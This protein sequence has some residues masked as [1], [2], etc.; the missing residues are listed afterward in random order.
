MSR[1]FTEAELEELRKAD[2]EIE[3]DFTLTQEDLDFSRNL[4][5]EAK[6]DKLDNRGRK[7]AA[8]QAAYREANREKLR[9]YQRDYQRKRREAQKN[10]ASRCARPESG[11]GT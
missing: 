7:I 8:Q 5:R 9:A 10:A 3:E 1:L 4:D 6:L 11:L 2:E